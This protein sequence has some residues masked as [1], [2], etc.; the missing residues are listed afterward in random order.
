MQRLFLAFALAASL[1]ACASPGERTLPS[2]TTA[3]PAD[4]LARITVTRSPS[5][6]YLAVPADITINDQRAGS[7]MLSET[8]QADV[9]AGQA[10]VAATARA[11]P[12]RSVL[13]L[14]TAPGG[15]YTIEVAPSFS[16]GFFGGFASGEQGGLFMLTIT[17]ADPPIGTPAAPIAAM[18]VAAS[19]PASAAD[20][21]ARLAELRRLRD[22]GL[23]AE[24]VYREEQRRILAR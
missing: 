13:R 19:A 7:I 17:S 14:P 4:G 21:E 24:D 16:N 22:R 9:P 5:M 20:R 10:S 6:L 1:A 2:P 8:T 11:N 15:R 23:I 18:P 3:A 12:G